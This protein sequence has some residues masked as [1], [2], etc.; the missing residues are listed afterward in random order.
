MNEAQ[1]A[2]GDP[3]LAER[4]QAGERVYWVCPRIGT[5]G[6]DKPGATGRLRLVA[7]DE[8]VREFGVEL[9]HGKLPPDERSW[10]LE[11]FGA[12]TSACWSRPP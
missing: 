3:W 8:R 7:A 6:D 1:D 11:R 4:M 10:R 2:E 9:V 12:G 5:D